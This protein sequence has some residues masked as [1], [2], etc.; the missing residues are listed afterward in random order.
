MT[1]MAIDRVI[2]GSLVE[3]QDTLGMCADVIVVDQ[4]IHT[5]WG[6]MLQGREMWSQTLTTLL[7]VP[8]GTEVE[9][10]SV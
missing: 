4:I 6:I 1:M 9:V 5:R 3:T 8:S 7:P 10:F 2:Q